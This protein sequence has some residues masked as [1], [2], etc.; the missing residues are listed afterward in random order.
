VGNNYTEEEEPM[1]RS[2]RTSLFAT[3]CVPFPV[4]ATVAAPCRWK[5][6]GP[7]LLS[8]E[9]GGPAKKSLRFV[10]TLILLAVLVGGTLAQSAEPEYPNRPLRYIVAFPP[11]GASDI[12]ARI[13]APALSVQLGQQVVVDNRSGAAGTIGAEIAAHATPDGYT[14]FACNI[15]SLA[16]SP[17]LYRK[18]GYDP[19]A[20][21]APIGLIASNPN[22]LSVN[23]SVPAASVAEFIGLVKSRPGQL[24][25][26][27]AGVGTSPQLSMELF[28]M[29]AGIDIVHIPY[30]G[31]G[32]A[33][34][35]L[36]GGQ[37]QAM[38]S[39]VPSVIGA[40]RAGKVRLLGVTSAT[41][42]PDLPDV[43]TIAESGMPGFEVI[44]W[45]GLC[46]PAGVP[47][48]ALARIRA[49]LA[50][51]LA[52]PDT[53]KHLADQS[54]QPKP[55]DPEQFA[56]FMRAEREK[57]TKLVKDVGIPQK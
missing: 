14:L 10:V 11:G 46:T 38:F 42:D 36:V 53:R 13:A 12:V 19:A 41:R 39:T 7:I 2:V 4:S 40:T 21:F 22:A 3:F 15:A 55:L 37:V 50:A 56:V 18:L 8:F 26:A 28:K 1:N 9:V 24:N 31:V 30:K 47:K 43:P 34:V 51:A 20:D 54:F 5:C 52:L 23:F 29:K 6:A 49:A 27:S 35:D 25:Y 17:A 45:Q 32:A 16:V 57:W 48:A 44:S 33:L